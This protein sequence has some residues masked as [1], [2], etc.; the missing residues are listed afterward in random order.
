MIFLKLTVSKHIWLIDWLFTVLRPT[1]EYF[2]Y[3]E[4]S[5]AG[6]GL[7]N[8]GLCSALRAFEQGGIFIMPHLLWHGGSFFPVSSEGPP[9]RLNRLLRHT[10]ECGRSILT[11]ILTG[12]V[13]VAFYDTQGGCGGPILT[14]ILTGGLS[15]HNFVTSRSLSYTL[16]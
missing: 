9:H 15:I 7:Q 3:M 11:R 12:P 1:Q 5:I 4:T 14:R 6:E 16:S 13:S 8:F 2:T 10:R